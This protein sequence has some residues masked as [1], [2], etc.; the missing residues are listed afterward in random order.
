MKHECIYH[1]RDCQEEKCPC[2]SY[3]EKLVL[4]KEEDELTAYCEDFCPI[5]YAVESYNSNT[6]EYRNTHVKLS[7]PTEMCS[8]VTKAFI[9]R[10]RESNKE[11]RNSIK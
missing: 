1:S 10:R 8:A 6:H 5:Y 11:K 9:L 4:T 7:C 3:T 2:L